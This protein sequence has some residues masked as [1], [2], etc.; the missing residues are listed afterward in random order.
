MKTNKIPTV[1]PCW[2]VRGGLL[3][4]AASVAFLLVFYYMPEF[5]AWLSEE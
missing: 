3:F 5:I 4:I 1:S 2:Y